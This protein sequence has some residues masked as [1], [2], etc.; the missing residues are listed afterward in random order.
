MKKRIHLLP[1]LLAS[2]GSAANAAPA[3]QLDKVQMLFERPSH[4]QAAI[5]QLLQVCVDAGSTDYRAYMFLGVIARE[6]HQMDDAAALLEKAHALAPQESAPTLELALTREWRHE[7]D[8][9]RALYQRVL[10][11]DHVSRPALLGVARVDRSQYHFEAAGRIY[12]ALLQV[13]P[14]DV[15]ARDGLASVALANR[16]FDV[17][18]DGYRAVLKDAPDNSEAQA[19]L[20]AVD[21]SWRYQLDMSAGAISSNMGT[22]GTGSIDLLAYLDATD[23]LE[24]GFLHNTE[25]LLSAQLSEQTLLPSDDLRV[26]YY[27]TVPLDYHWSLTYD[28]RHHDGLP[29]EHWVQANVGRYFAGGLQW[30]V[31][32][33]ESFGAARWNT[34]LVQAGLMVPVTGTWDF[35]G[36]GYFAR[37]PKIGLSGGYRENY[38]LNVDVERQG[39]GNSFFSAGAGYSPDIDNTDVHARIVL[40]VADRSAVLFSIEHISI[41]NEFQVTGGLRF[42]LQ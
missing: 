14:Q 5:T 3:C 26:G 8:A 21:S 23:A 41:N 11:G 33:R 34:Q 25:E 18:R 36:T 15:D 1:L 12:R 2:V 16:Q 13:N 4:D 29:S 42:F 17:A 27:R 32:A 35:V 39:P 38:A 24:L 22:A 20:V 19:G 28:F 9:A 10:A 6:R 7:P 40:P 37:Y 30:F 31:G